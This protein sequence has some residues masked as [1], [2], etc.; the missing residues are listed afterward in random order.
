MLKIFLPFMAFAVLEILS[1]AVPV[2]AEAADRLAGSEW[3][4]TG[5]DK[6]FVQFGSG[7][8]LAGNAGCNNFFGGYEVAADGSIAIGPLGS[9]RM[10][11]PEP[12]MTQEMQFLDMLQ[13]VKRFERDGTRLSLMD[14]S[15]TVLAEL[16]QRDAD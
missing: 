13:G 12:E 11:C 7:G 15:G 3:G 14:G 2:P 9:T 8:K 10:A 1:T 16:V 6:P 4:M 5:K